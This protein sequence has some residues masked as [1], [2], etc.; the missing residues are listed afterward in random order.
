MDT[1]LTT[2]GTCLYLPFIIQCFRMSWSKDAWPRQILLLALFLQWTT[3]MHLP[4][5][6]YI[7]FGILT[8]AFII[9]IAFSDRSSV[10]RALPGNSS[11]IITLLYITCFTISLS[12][13]VVPL[14]GVLAILSTG[15]PLLIFTLIGTSL[16]TTSEERVRM[17]RAACSVAYIFI[18]MTLLSWLLSCAQLH[19]YPWQWPVLTKMKIEYLDTFHYIFRWLGGLHGYT[20]PSYNLLPLF[21]ITCLAIDLRRMNAIKPYAWWLLWA[22][23]A[24][25]TLLAQSRMGLLFVGIELVAYLILIQ[26]TLRRR[27]IA[28]IATAAIATTAIGCTLP[29]WQ[30]YGADPIRDELTAKTLRYI[31][32]KPWTG[33]G[34][35]ALNPVEICH[36]IGDNSWPRVG[37]ITPEMRVEDWKPKT[38]ML[39]HNQWLAD[40]AHAGIIAGLLCLALYLFLTLQA[41]RTH[42]WAALTFILIFIIFSFLEPPLYIGK[43]LYLFALLTAYLTAVQNASQPWARRGSSSPLRP[44]SIV[45]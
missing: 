31:Q 43:G 39:P 25:I 2:L 21:A 28:S 23:G 45:P 16:H 26:P 36:T 22:A 17:L 24:L 19:I 29:F 10:I 1:L 33:A 38:R 18:A 9:Y 41:F 34:A 8:V 32:A 13:S 6:M 11:L 27:I 5:V 12:W 35:G 42:Q 37:T 4:S 40:C 3:I 30:Q 7:T 15:G 44:T 20:H 14:K